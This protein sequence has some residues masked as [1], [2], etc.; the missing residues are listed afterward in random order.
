MCCNLNSVFKK[1]L[2]ISWNTLLFSPVNSNVPCKGNWLPEEGIF[3]DHVKSKMIGVRLLRIDIPIAY[4]WCHRNVRCTD[5]SESWSRERLIYRNHI[6]ITWMKMIKDIK[7]RTDSLFLTG[8]ECLIM[9]LIVEF[10]SNFYK[11]TKCG[12]CFQ[13]KYGTINIVSWYS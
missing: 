6:G 5:V 1:S 13:S 10:P 4:T 3:W 8:M 2:I 9:T 12:E 11:T 7:G